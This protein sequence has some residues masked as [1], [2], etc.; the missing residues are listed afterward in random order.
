M[1]RD[2]E[3]ARKAKL[4]LIEL[5]IS[6]DYE[7][8]HTEADDILCKLLEDLG[9]EDVSIAFEGVPKWYA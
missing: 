7:T 8:A 9:Y 2:E 4:K 1:E 3:L 6:E 5:H